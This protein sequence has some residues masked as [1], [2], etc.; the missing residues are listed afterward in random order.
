MIYFHWHENFVN[1]E[2]A[3]WAEGAAAIAP[4]D[5]LDLNAREE[6]DRYQSVSLV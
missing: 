4:G 6:R 2:L 1:W 5:S 3:G